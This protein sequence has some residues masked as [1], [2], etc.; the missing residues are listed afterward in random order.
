MKAGKNI[1]CD[2][3]WYSGVA[4]S[5]AKGMN[6]DWCMGSDEGLIEP[7]VVIFLRGNPEKLAQRSGYGE[8]RFEKV[9]F[10]EKVNDGFE[11]LLKKL[12]KEYV[13]VVDIND[14]NIEEVKKDVL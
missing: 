6:L 1:V 3:Y 9:E 5:Y 10:Q 8:E 13:K 2:R 7:D 12:G 11:K 4:Y 14:K